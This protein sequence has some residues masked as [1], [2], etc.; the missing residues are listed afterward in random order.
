MQKEEKERE[1]GV[2]MRVDFHHFRGHLVQGHELG[3]FRVGAVK[4]PC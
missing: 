2:C 3:W 1:C 4:P